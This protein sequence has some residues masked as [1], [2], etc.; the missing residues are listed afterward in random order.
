MK[1]WL[2]KKWFNMVTRRVLRRR[3]QRAGFAL[4]EINAMFIR[5]HVGR[6]LRRQ[7]FRDLYRNPVSAYEIIE[8]ALHGRNA[9]LERK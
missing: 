7:F 6:K 8:R 5:A 1:L 9:V 4:L 3:V 2:K